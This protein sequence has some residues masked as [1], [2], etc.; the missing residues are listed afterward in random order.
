MLWNLG[1]SISRSFSELLEINVHIQEA[2]SEEL[3]RDV[4]VGKFVMPDQLQ[5]SSEFDPHCLFHFFVLVPHLHYTWKIT[6]KRGVEICQEEI[7]LS[8]KT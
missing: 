2:C 8:Y 6:I 3:R 7:K 4:M 5:V 1:I